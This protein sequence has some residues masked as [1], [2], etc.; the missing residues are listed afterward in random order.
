[1]IDRKLRINKENAVATAKCPTCGQENHVCINKAG[2]HY[3]SCD[4]LYG[5]CGT[6]L[7]GGKYSPEKYQGLENTLNIIDG[8][9]EENEL[10]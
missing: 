6:K 3:Y 1:M 2:V 8:E 7:Q 10:I 5:G 4:V 9:H